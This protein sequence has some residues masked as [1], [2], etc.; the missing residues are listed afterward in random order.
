MMRKLLLWMAR[1][2]WLRE[3]L[4]GLWFAKR[5]VRRFMPGEDPENALGAPA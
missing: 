4:P 1:N 2:P 3:R 5:A